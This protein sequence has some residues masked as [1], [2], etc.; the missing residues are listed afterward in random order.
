MWNRIKSCVTG[1]FLSVVAFTSNATA[2][3]A[4]TADPSQGIED[5]TTF[6]DTALLAAINIG[7]VVLGWY[8]VRMLIKLGKS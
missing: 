1:A 5:V 4:M 3:V 6:A 2:Q 7:I 8:Y